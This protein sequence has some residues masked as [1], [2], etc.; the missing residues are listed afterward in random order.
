MRE[1]G[2]YWVRRGDIWNVAEY[3][4]GGWILCGHVIDHDDTYFDEIGEKVERKE[5]TTL[6]EYIDADLKGIKNDYWKS[7]D[8]QS[9]IIAV[10]D[11][12]PLRKGIVNGINYKE[13]LKKYMVNVSWQEGSCFLPGVG[14]ISDE[15]NEEL[16]RLS[17]QAFID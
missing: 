13:L 7:N 2:Y 3:F 11:G 15:E 10:V 4:Y 14:K 12:V 1:N 8:K 6:S 17:D 16:D 9:D 5:P